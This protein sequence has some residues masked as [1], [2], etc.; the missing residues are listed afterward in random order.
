MYVSKVYSNIKMFNETLSRP[1]GKIQFNCESV[2]KN[3]LLYN[4]T[5]FKTHFL[6]LSLVDFSKFY[7]KLKIINFTLE[8][9]LNLLKHK[10]QHIAISYYLSHITTKCPPPFKTAIKNTIL[11]IENVC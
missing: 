3:S 6:S 5:K 11:I 9:I 8:I 7:Y 1:Y 4:K 10:F 2:N